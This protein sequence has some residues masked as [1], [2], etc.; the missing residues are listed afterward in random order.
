MIYIAKTDSNCVCYIRIWSL[1]ITQG[2]PGVW[3][4]NIHICEVKTKKKILSNVLQVLQFSPVT[5]S[6]NNRNY[7]CKCK[8]NTGK[9]RNV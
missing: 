1:N 6:Q 5:D 4:E 7:V 3:S 8:H 9:T 2:W